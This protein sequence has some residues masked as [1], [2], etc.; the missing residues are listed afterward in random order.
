ME[1]RDILNLLNSRS[2]KAITALSE[3]FGKRLYLT[4]V[5]LL[6]SPR[7]A[8][9]C[10]NDTYL[11]VWNAIPPTTP[12]CFSA[13]VYRVG[14]NIAINRLRDNTAQKRSAAEVPLD[15]L[16]AFL[17]A[18]S[19]EDSRV[20]GQLINRWLDTQSRTTRL[21]FLRRYWF[22][23]T[24]KEIAGALGMKESAV[25]ARLSRSREHLKAYLSKE[26]YYG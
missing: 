20:L 13:Y 23:D 1:D 18:P 15:E 12:H 2:E 25:S 9:E 10:V 19:T 8:E 24:V 5:N 11:A 7:D 6:G 22:G 4:A 26:G 17:Q 14:R 3:R 21:V 16:S